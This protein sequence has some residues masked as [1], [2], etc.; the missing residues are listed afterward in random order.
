MQAES[1]RDIPKP[2]REPLRSR[3]VAAAL[4]GVRMATPRHAESRATEAWWEERL[5]AVDELPPSER[6]QAVSRIGTPRW[7]QR[8]AEELATD[9][10]RAAA[11]RQAR[12]Y[13][14]AAGM[15]DVP[16]A[17]PTREQYAAAVRNMRY[18]MRR[19]S[20]HDRRFAAGRQPMVDG[21]P[22]DDDA[23]LGPNDRTDGADAWS[24]V[25]QGELDME[26]GLDEIMEFH[27]HA[28]EDEHGDGM[29]TTEDTA[30][31]AMGTPQVLPGLRALLNGR[32]RPHSI[33]D[34]AGYDGTS[35]VPLGT[36]PY[37]TLSWFLCPLIA[38][39]AGLG[40]LFPTAVA[41]RPDMIVAWANAGGWLAADNFP[42]RNTTW[43][44]LVER[45][46]S[47]VQDWHTSDAADD[48]AGMINE[49]GGSVA[50][51]LIRRMDGLNHWPAALQEELVRRVSEQ[52]RPLLRDEE[53]VYPFPPIVHSFEVAL[54]MAANGLVMARQQHVQNG[55]REY[56]VM[57]SAD[58]PQSARCHV[59]ECNRPFQR[60][61]TLPALQCSTCSNVCHV[62]CA[63]LC[64]L[65]TGPWRCSQCTGEPY[66]RPDVTAREDATTCCICFDDF[67]PSDMI[68][69][70][71]THA[72]H[73]ESMCLACVLGMLDETPDPSLHAQSVP[74]L[75]CP[76]CR[77]SISE[78]CSAAGGPPFHLVRPRTRRGVLEAPIDVDAAAEEAIG[79]DDDDVVDLDAPPRRRD[80]PAPPTDAV[81]AA[82]AE[83]RR[84]ARDDAQG[85]NLSDQE[86]VRLARQARDVGNDAMCRHLLAQVRDIPGFP[87]GRSPD[88]ETRAMYA[89]RRSEFYVLYYG[90]SMPSDAVYRRFRNNLAATRRRRQSAAPEQHS[91]EARRPVVARNAARIGRSVAD[92]DMRELPRVDFQ[93]LLAV[94]PLAGEDDGDATTAEQ[95][96]ALMAEQANGGTPNARLQQACCACCN[97]ELFPGETRRLPRALRT[98]T[99][100]YV[101]TICC[102]RGQVMVRPVRCAPIASMLNE[103]TA[104]ERR[105]CEQY[106]DEMMLRRPGR[107]TPASMA[108]QFLRVLNSFLALASQIV[109]RREMPARGM[110]TYVVNARITHLMGPLANNDRSPQFAQMYVHDALLGGNDDGGMAAHNSNREALHVYLRRSRSGTSTGN[111]T[112]QLL[113]QMVGRLRDMLR[114]VRVHLATIATPV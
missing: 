80:R 78:M 43:A 93:G 54:T 66:A 57:S 18:G 31:T 113:E 39:A 67:A 83:Y 114:Q 23:E 19:V 20:A 44:R 49:V 69:F 100:M 79:D 11:R 61:I 70:G 105:T 47:A 60:M 84:T 36:Q 53:T 9:P 112:T 72:R 46:S 88:D 14:I 52:T 30:M 55:V 21:L 101:G 89:R 99:R 8:F 90:E 87:P 75:R 16:A 10:V 81:R 59:A 27:W 4:A 29:H 56:Y 92:G 91:P 86:L 94:G 6:L 96:Q 65:P 35:L 42:L 63:Q 5:D 103:S 17:V 22:A 7:T 51:G 98:T 58:L 64:W 13:R 108:R 34:G 3:A 2:R 28:G 33:G 106:L 24:Q 102:H 77:V 62:R 32:S 1:P 97:A 73:P 37:T 38:D 45:F 74:P 95:Q 104:T 107:L 25:D 12:W 82:Y 15:F 48:A 110:P 68:T 26:A 76:M 111:L 71:S 40:W 85:A 50:E 109:R 41:P